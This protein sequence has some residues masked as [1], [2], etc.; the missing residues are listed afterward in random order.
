[1]IIDG[2]HIASDTSFEMMIFKDG[3]GQQDHNMV[4]FLFSI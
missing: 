1:M 3:H 2:T 4:S